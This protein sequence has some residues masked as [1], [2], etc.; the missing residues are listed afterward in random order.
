MIIWFINK[1]YFKLLNFYFSYIITKMS[2]VRFMTNELSDTINFD[3]EVSKNKKLL[4]CQLKGF[5]RDKKRDKICDYLEHEID[6]MGLFH[7]IFNYEHD[8]NNMKTYKCCEI[9]KKNY[10]FDENKYLHE[11]FNITFNDQFILRGD[12]LCETCN[13]WNERYYSDKIGPYNPIFCFECITCHKRNENCSDEMFG[14]SHP[15]AL[16]TR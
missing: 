2:N 6:E 13:L 10:L 9:C 11:L 15:Y 8:E 16:E 12:R 3:L 4:L 7:I 5:F 1:K 14:N